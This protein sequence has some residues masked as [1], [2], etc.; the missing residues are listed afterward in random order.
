MV[1]YS[2]H[3]YA[4]VLR[5]CTGAVDSLDFDHAREF[6]RQWVKIIQAPSVRVRWRNEVLELLGDG[7]VNACITAE[8]CTSIKGSPSMISVSEYPMYR[9]VYGH[10][11]RTLHHQ[12]LKSVLSSN[13]LFATITKRMINRLAF[14]VEKLKAFLNISQDDTIPT[15][16]YA[17][18]FEVCVCVVWYPSYP[19]IS[20]TSA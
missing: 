13:I 9:V 6:E 11:S 16:S 19:P 3:L 10:Q 14:P 8:I 12:M 17:D 4:T 1:S 18:A 2:K 15:K 7:V 20:K 5:A